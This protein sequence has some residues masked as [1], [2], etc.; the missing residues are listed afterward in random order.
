MHTLCLNK[1]VVVKEQLGWVNRPGVRGNA[2][3]SLIGQDLQLCSQEIQGPEVLQ[4]L[5]FHAACSVSAR[6]GLC[7]LL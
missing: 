6:L 2:A 3:A 5:A 7:Y 4:L 1:A